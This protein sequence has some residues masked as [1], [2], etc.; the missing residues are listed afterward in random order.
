MAISERQIGRSTTEPGVYVR[1]QDNSVSIK[2]RVI[3]ATD[4]PLHKLGEQIQTAVASAITEIAGMRVS[5]VDV[6]FEDV[7]VKA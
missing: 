3:A 2:L 1:V 5:T 6:S 7:R 4:V